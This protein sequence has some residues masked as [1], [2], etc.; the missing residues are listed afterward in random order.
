MCMQQGAS[1]IAEQIRKV[2]ALNVEVEG[3]SCS[4]DLEKTRLFSS[5]QIFRITDKKLSFDMNTKAILK[6]N[7]A[8]ILLIRF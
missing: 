7:D 8:Q 2:F 5:H 6:K 4:E 3:R 1:V